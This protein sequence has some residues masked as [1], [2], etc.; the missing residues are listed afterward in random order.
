[1]ANINNDI[2]VGVFTKLL[3]G[4]ALKA[5]VAQASGGTMYYKIY[6]NRAPQ[7]LPGTTADV[8]LPFVVF[9]V[10]PINPSRDSGTKWYE[11]SVQF[12]VGSLTASECET[13]AGLITDLMEDCEATL[14]IGTYATVQVLREPQVNLGEIEGVHNIAVQYGIMVQ[15]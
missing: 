6:Y 9:D 12:V 13:I 8:S 1:M 7:V 15:K 2:R 14:T 10:L 4:T 5:A 3:T 11:T